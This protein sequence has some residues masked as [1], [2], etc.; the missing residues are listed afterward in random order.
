MRAAIYARY[1]TDMQSDRSIEDQVRLCRDMAAR[2]GDE[3]VAVYADRAVSGALLQNRPEAMRLL[4]DARARAFDVILIEALDRISRDLEHSA[5]LFK[6][7]THAG[8]RIVTD[9]DGDVTPMVVALKGLMAQ[10]FLTDLAAKVR[11]GQRGRAADGLV[12]GGRAYGYE[13]VVELDAKGERKRGLRRPHPTEANV[14]RRIFEEY[15]RGKSVHAIVADLNAEGV[16]G[17]RGGLWSAS[18]VSGHRGRLG[19]LWNEAYIGRLLWDRTTVVKDPDTG[20]RLAR[21]NPADRQ[22]AVDAPH[23]RLVSDDLWQ[24]AQARKAA[25]S[26]HDWPAHLHRRP[27]RLLSGLVRCALC[28][29]PYAVH[30]KDRMGCSRHFQNRSCA[31]G[32]TVQIAEV[33]RRVL[34]GLAGALDRIDDVADFVQAYHEERKRLA[35]EGERRREDLERRLGKIER[36]LPVVV[37]L[38]VDL[39][40]DSPALKAELRQLEDQRRAIAAEI[41]SLGAP[42]EPV[43]DLHPKLLEERKAALRELGTLLHE[44]EQNKAELAA[45]LRRVVVSIEIRPTDRRG[46]PEI[47][48]RGVISELL[49]LPEQKGPDRTEMTVG[50]AEGTGF[51]RYSPV[52]AIAC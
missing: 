2:R 37:K 36:R 6:R 12:A 11:R 18:T 48:V 9:S 14:V 43:V 26:L 49:G 15:V 28:G 31:N 17:P 46:K 8:V 51:R 41:A 34:E 1:S 52:I 47:T 7:V 45:R 39:D 44:R 23:L 3:V 29:G 16:P 4:A 5:H 22:L 38:L 25:Q 10:L 40:G 24:A 20:R 33:E 32:A 42:P 50:L 27:K 35:G 21:E 19:I 30:T 13:V